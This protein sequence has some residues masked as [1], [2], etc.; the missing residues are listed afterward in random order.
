[1]F[2]FSTETTFNKVCYISEWETSTVIGISKIP[3]FLKE[4]N[5]EVEG[6]KITSKIWS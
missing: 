5:Q 2:S 4:V 3:K 6:N 1:M